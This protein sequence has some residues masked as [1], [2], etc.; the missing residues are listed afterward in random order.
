[1]I[2]TNQNLEFLFAEQQLAKAKIKIL[3]IKLWNLE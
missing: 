2:T 3:K 1:M